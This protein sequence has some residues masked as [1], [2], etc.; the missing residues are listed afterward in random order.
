[1]KTSHAVVLGLAL[2]MGA[3]LG[4]CTGANEGAAPAAKAG[5]Q[6]PPAANLSPTEK[7][8]QAL[9]K[10]VTVNATQSP[11]AS[12]LT[13]Q[14]AAIAICKAAGVPYQWDKS[15]GL[16]GEV[17]RRF[18]APLNVSGVPGKQV[19]TDLLSP[20]GIRFEVDENGVYLCR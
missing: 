19:L 7:Y 13:V 11:D 10:P 1:M 16:A 4:G 18:I 2:I 12:Q 20:L 3:I 6:T 8:R 15:S 14:Y 17:C 9:N 5:A